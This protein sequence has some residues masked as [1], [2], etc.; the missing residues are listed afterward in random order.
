MSTFNDK[1]LVC[2]D[3]GLQFVWSAGEQA[4]FADRG[5][6]HQ[7]KRCKPCKQAK[8][9]RMAGVVQS[10]RSVQGPRVMH[11]VVCAQCSRPTTVP[12]VPTQGRPV[13]C[14]GC[15]QGARD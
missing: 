2:N 1:Y 14:R 15:F 7:P 12:F 11:E 6:T 3:C 5:L 13:Y 9:A 4:F 10:P 8:N